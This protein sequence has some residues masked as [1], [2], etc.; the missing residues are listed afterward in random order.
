MLKQSFPGSVTILP[1]ADQPSDSL[2]SYNV[3]QLIRSIFPIGSVCIYGGRDSFISHYSGAFDTCEFP[4]ADYRPGTEIR[5]TIGNIVPSTIEGRC[6]AIY[7][8]QNQYPRAFVCVDAI[9]HNGEVAIVAGKKPEDEGALRL[10]GGFLNPRET[11]EAAVRREILEEVGCSVHD[12]KYITSRDT[13]DW[14]FEGHRDGLTTL[15]FSCAYLSGPISGGDDLPRAEWV[16][17]RDKR[18]LKRFIPGH[19]ELIIAFMETR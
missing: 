11:P 12:P 7:S 17:L 19:Q 4:P 3:D 14:R 13:Y 1:I 8:T 6:G 16:D 15:C 2:W 5:E 10:P 18:I 9:I